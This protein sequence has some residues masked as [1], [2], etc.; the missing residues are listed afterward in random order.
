MCKPIDSFHGDIVF[1]EKIIF[2][3]LPKSG[4][5]SR[6]TVDAFLLPLTS[7]TEVKNLWR[8]SSGVLWCIENAPKAFLLSMVGAVPES[9]LQGTQDHLWTFCHEVSFGKRIFSE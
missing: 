1:L 8:P 6:T 2:P 5:V 3:M 9:T 7:A 4:M